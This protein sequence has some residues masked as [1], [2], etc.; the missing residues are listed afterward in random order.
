M[1]VLMATTEKIVCNKGSA[2]GLIKD[3]KEYLIL[4]RRKDRL[5]KIG[6][7]KL[8]LVSTTMCR[9]DIID[10]IKNNHVQKNDI[11]ISSEFLNNKSKK[12]SIN[13]KKS[14]PKSKYNPFGPTK[15][16]GMELSF[17][18]GGLIID[19][20]DRSSRFGGFG[21]AAGT[22]YRL[23]IDNNFYFN[24]KCE[25]G[26]KYI[27]SP[28]SYREYLD[29]GGQSHSSSLLEYNIDIEICFKN[30]GF[31]YGYRGYSGKDINTY[32]WWYDYTSERAWDPRYAGLFIYNKSIISLNGKE[33]GILIRFVAPQFSTRS[34]RVVE[35]NFHFYILRPSKPN[36]FFNFYFLKYKS[37]PPHGVNGL[38][39][40]A[41]LGYA[42]K[43][44]SY[45]IDIGIGYLFQ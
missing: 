21:I 38:I 3:D 13:N 28:S 17:N 39:W 26:G 25:I 5:Y 10:L 30:I 19:S 40:Y 2:D 34:T 8:D 6:V 31:F 36:D 24:P 9:L 27:D 29:S 32:N 44:S 35:H 41:E 33:F 16:L 7:A 22:Q 37:L 14:I 4:R 1:L 43:I 11:I 42:P 12:M 23:L 45:K 18:L 15:K 20:G